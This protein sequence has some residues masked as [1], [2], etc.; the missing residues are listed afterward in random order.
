MT[1]SDVT[2]HEQPE[3]KK[4]VLNTLSKLHEAYRITI[5]PGLCII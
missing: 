3:I 1:Q 5:M 4:P 2:G